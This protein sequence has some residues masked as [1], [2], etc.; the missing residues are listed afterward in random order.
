MAKR[1]IDDD[2]L[3]ALANAIRS[4]TNSTDAMTPNEMQAIIE[5]LKIANEPYIEEVYD[6]N[7]KLIEARLIGSTTL[8]P[9]AFY[10]S[11]YLTL[12]ELP[13]GLTSIGD[14]AFCDCNNLALTELPE[15]L[16]SIGNCAFQYCY[17]LSEITFKGT[18]TSIKSR[19]FAGCT[20]LTILN[21][22]WSE[23]VVANAPWGA[24]NATINYDYIGG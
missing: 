10:D 6:S 19:A 7:N 12:I 1:V 4:K 18:P 11:T 9:Y 8:R 23:G 21:V 24:T 17:G 13:A 16:T 2:T 14:Y 20:N 5:G 3:T 22:P 15:G